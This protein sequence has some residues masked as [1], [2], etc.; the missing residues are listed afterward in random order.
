MVAN[1]N[2]KVA[3][4]VLENIQKVLFEKGKHCY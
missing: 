1:E 2:E 3:H 4:I